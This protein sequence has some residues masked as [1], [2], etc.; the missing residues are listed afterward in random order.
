MTTATLEKDELDSRGELQAQKQ[1][2][3][4]ERLAPDVQDHARCVENLFNDENKHTNRGRLELGQHIL[5]IHNSASGGDNT[6]GQ[7][8]IDELCKLFGWNSAELYAA[9]KFAKAFTKAQIDELCETP[10]S[11]GKIIS[12]T[13]LRVLATLKSAKKRDKLLKKA[14]KQCWTVS[15]VKEAVHGAR[16][17]NKT[18]TRGHPL[19]I[20][21]DL[22]TLIRQ[23]ERPINDFITR[24]EK[25]WEQPGH[26]LTVEAKKLPEAQIT[27]K[28]VER[29]KAHAESLR[30]LSAKAIEQAKEAEAAYEYLTSKLKAKSS[31][32]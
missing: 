30:K 2:K 4:L 21:K 8:V 14:I 17:K 16:N 5:A 27:A 32:A 9:M 1:K 28:E 12:Y 20:P 15:E 13:V 19:T 22:R 31:A 26:S 18:E 7:K 11:N 10:M 24:S 3:Y 25:I 29:I 6:Y 23:Q